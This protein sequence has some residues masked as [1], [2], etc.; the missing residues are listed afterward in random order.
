MRHSLDLQLT[1]ETTSL[2]KATDLLHGNCVITVSRDINYYLDYVI[3]HSDY[4]YISGYTTIDG[5]NLPTSESPRSN[6]RHIKI[7]SFESACRTVSRQFRRAKC[8]NHYFMFYQI[9]EEFI[10]PICFVEPRRE[11]IFSHLRDFIYSFIYSVWGK[12]IGY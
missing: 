9:K 6:H 2:W 5:P 4:D 10:L 1:K 7:I 11:L 12:T 8:T 3:R